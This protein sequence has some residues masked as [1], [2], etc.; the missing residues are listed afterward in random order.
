LLLD[1]T[2]H[3]LGV[4]TAGGYCEQVIGRNSPIPTEQTRIFSTS[5]DNQ[6]MVSVRV[7]QG[8]AR[9]TEDNQVLGAVELFGLR[10]G[11]RGEVKIAVTFM[12]DADGTLQVKAQ[13]TSTGR[14]QQIRINLVGA[15]GDA[16]VKRLRAR[17]ERMA[18][19]GG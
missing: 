10:Q 12:L 6:M 4:E 7:C 3:S 11:P 2:P 18:E 16:E 5:Q 13:D 17:H 8:E 9:R 14:A 19:R 1:V 15:L